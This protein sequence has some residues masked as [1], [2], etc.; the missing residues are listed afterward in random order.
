VSDVNPDIKPVVIPIR[1]VIAAPVP[2]VFHA[3]NIVPNSPTIRAV[4]LGIAVNACAVVLKPPV[5][6]IA[7]IAK[8]GAG[9]GQR[10]RERQSGTQGKTNDFLFHRLPP[11]RDSTGG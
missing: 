11:K 5:A 7:R 9:H 10:E 4:P 1:M 3:V 8:C 6:I 2:I